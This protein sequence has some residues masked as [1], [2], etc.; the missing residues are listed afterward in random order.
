MTN[1]KWLKWLVEI[2]DVRSWHNKVPGKKAML[3]INRKPEKSTQTTKEV[4]EE[5]IFSVMNFYHG[6]K[7]ILLFFHKHFTED[8]E[9]WT[10][11]KRASANG[12]IYNIF[13]G[14]S[15]KKYL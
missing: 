7:L 14:S 10:H 3:V 13:F 1:L 15:A 4:E 11:L 8:F 2:L 9:R 5:E 6:D 12:R